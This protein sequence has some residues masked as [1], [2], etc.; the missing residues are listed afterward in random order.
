MG[1]IERITEIMKPTSAP[2]QAETETIQAEQA[3]TDN[4]DN[5]IQT[6]QDAELETKEADAA[7][8]EAAASEEKTYS[9]EEIEAIIAERKKEW[10]ADRLHS[11]SKDSQIE[12]LK[13]EL[14]RRDLR[15]KV[16]ARLEE[17]D[18]PLGVAEFVQYTDEAGTMEHLEKVVTT[19]NQL[20]QDGVRMRL[21]GKTPEG[22]GAA[23]NVLNKASDP[24]ARTFLNAM[25]N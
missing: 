9:P 25:K 18:L 15:E 4:A 1:F 21:R 12:E 7:A 14:L 13:A 19:M 22:L 17:E 6:E 3:E 2:E 24:F 11:L 23:A 8:D 16:N 5:A 20:V 10:E